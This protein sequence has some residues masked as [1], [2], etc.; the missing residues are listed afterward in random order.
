MKFGDKNALSPWWIKETSNILTLS[1]PEQ[2]FKFLRDP[3]SK[4]SGKKQNLHSFSNSYLSKNAKFFL[5]LLL[6]HYLVS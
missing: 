2:F 1:S 4:M 5:Q 3:I 6:S